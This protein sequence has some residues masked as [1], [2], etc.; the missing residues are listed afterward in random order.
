M[1]TINTLFAI[2]AL[3]VAAT[4]VA[5][6][7][8]SAADARVRA[9]LSDSVIMGQ[10][11]P[12]THQAAVHHTSAIDTGMSVAAGRVQ[13]S[14]SN[15]GI[16]GNTRALATDSVDYAND[17]GKSVSATRVEHALHESA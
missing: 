12:V 4:G 11:Q 5:N 9:A 6:A 15:S 8:D 2:A 10:A 16:Q 13:Q 14:I 1:R 3:S 17:A 7:S